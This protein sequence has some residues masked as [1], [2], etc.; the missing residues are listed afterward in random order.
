LTI[1]APTTGSSRRRTLVLATIAVGAFVSVLDQTGVSLALPELATHFSATIPVVQWV[2]LGF[3]LVTG[4]LLIPM[5]RLSDL[6]GRKRVYVIGFV[7]FI[8]GALLAGLSPSLGAVI[9]ARLFQGIG[10]AMIQ[11]NG[12]AMALATFPPSERGKVIGL[13]MTMV[14]M[15]AV[16]GPVVS[17]VVVDFLGWRAV[18]LMGVPLGII[19]L[20]SAIVILNPDSKS[21]TAD[22]PKSEKFDWLGAFLSATSVAVFLLVMT[23]AYRIGWSSPIVLSAF[24]AALLLF[25]TFIYWERR[26][27]SPMLALDL[28][29]SKA[30]SLGSASSFFTFLAG[31][32]VFSLMPFYLQGVAGLSPAQTGLII[33]PTAVLF[34]ITGP[35]SGR[36][37]DKYGPKS[38]EFLGL[39]SLLAGMLIL[40]T[41]SEST[42]LYVIQ[43]SLI[44]QGVGMGTFNP[45]N[46]SSV[47]AT[48]DLSRIGVATAFTNM[49]RNTANVTGIGLAITIVTMRMG[50]LG[51]EPSLD[52]V[53]GGGE[54]V[55]AA[56]SQGLRLAFLTLGAF[57]VLAGVS[58]WVKHLGAPAREDILDVVLEPTTESRP[59]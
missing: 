38:F 24:G 39:A 53:T 46:Q 11:A 14:G 51:F 15:G 17:G 35:I 49:V 52:A 23:N 42:S 3:I 16:G 45:P 56:F 22:T 5:G 40:G 32:A 12:M 58:T 28:F 47:L 7:V 9:A 41:I 4:S 50:A 2:A 48:V 33:A 19:S 10:A 30:F 54:G 18:F 21:H 34:A 27:A 20:I 29:E 1:D 36:L 43:L 37:S 26:T 25:V 57:I 6:I 59:S 8:A 55:E 44:F 13:F 31:T